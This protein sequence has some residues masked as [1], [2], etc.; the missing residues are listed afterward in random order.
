MKI[1]TFGCFFFT[2][3]GRDLKVVRY[4]VFIQLGVG[5]ILSLSVTWIKEDLEKRPDQTP[6]SHTMLWLEVIW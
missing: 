1:E 2:K 4:K 5:G 3:K 6:D